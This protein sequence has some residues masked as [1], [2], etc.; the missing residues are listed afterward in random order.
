MAPRNR[1]ET[2]LTRKHVARLERER[3]QSAII[4]WVAAVLVVGIFL[5]FIFVSFTSGALHFGNFNIDYLL[6]NKTV[7]Q[8]GEDKVTLREFQNY[9]RL[10]R[11]QMLGQYATYYQYQQFGL[12]VT[13]QLQQLETQ[14]AADGAQDLGQQVVDALVN[15]L[16]IHQEAA[17]RG[18]V[19]S[20]EE[21]QARVEDIFGYYPAG[22]PSPTL[23]PTEL[24]FS[25]LS[26]DQLKMVSPT[27]TATV[28]PNGTPSETP[29][30][31]ETPSP[32]LT[33]TPD[34]TQTATIT[35]TSTPTIT[36]TPTETSAPTETPTL[37]P[38]I[39]A[40]FTP[41]NTPTITPTATPYTEQGFQDYFNNSMTQYAQLGLTEDD[42]RKLVASDLLRTRLFDIITA[43]VP[44]ASEQVWARHILVGTE[45][46]ALTIL[47]EM[48]NGA[49]FGAEAAK[50]STDTSNKDQGG[51]LGWFEKGRMV[52]E[53]EN[54][55]FALKV[56]EISQPVQTQFGWHIIQVIGHEDR[57]LD[58]SAIDQAKQQKFNDF[59]A[60]ARQKAEDAGLLQIF[61]IW[62]K[63]VPT[64]PNLDD[65]F[66][67]QP[68]Q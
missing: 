55:A 49:E 17:A 53:F 36:L 8:L 9:V 31:S 29:I 61:D 27:S 51:D 52:A 23:T 64:T 38:T 30:P 28:T 40:T 11:Q 25:T 39:T 20:D 16:L 50:Y 65:L 12:D 13:Q 5:G 21:I 58:A 7:V 18:I 67:P 63:H 24:V 15:D 4:R 43:D 10:Q 60:E 46:E 37:T 56:G 59:L 1:R 47:E 45:A 6:R 42:Y 26:A 33:L 54:A 32:T 2:V 48:K 41:S 66:N 35:I 57:P 68:T 19:L 3:R 22:T 44:T 14:L 34:F 62:M